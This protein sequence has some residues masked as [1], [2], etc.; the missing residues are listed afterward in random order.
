VHHFNDDMEEEDMST[1]DEE[2]DDPPPWKGVGFDEH[3]HPFAA[4]RQRRRR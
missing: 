2:D 1:E 3:M 4:N